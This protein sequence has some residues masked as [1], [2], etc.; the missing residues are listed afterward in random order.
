MERSRRT[1]TA[2]RAITSSCEAYASG[3]GWPADVGVLSGGLGY[4][5]EAGV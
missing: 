3:G 4:T 5:L 2:M 1:R